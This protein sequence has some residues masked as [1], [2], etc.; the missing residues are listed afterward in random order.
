MNGIVQYFCL[1]LQIGADADAHVVLMI[2]RHIFS[3]NQHE[4]VSTFSLTLRVSYAS[5]IVQVV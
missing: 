3:G 4:K 5:V 2:Q 1:T